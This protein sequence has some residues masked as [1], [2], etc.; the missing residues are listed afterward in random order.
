MDNIAVLEVN[1]E[2]IE[3]AKEDTEATNNE[4]SI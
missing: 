4:I 3:S 2:S 1:K